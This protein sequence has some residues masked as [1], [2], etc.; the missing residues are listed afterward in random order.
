[1]PDA[2][3]RAL[4]ELG[5]EF[6]QFGP[7]V[8]LNPS[9]AEQFGL[10]SIASAT[11]NL[12]PGDRNL[13]RTLGIAR[14]AGFEAVS[15][16]AGG[17]LLNDAEVFGRAG[18]IA[19]AQAELGVRVVL[20]THRATI[21]ESISRTVEIAERF[22]D[23]RFNLDLSH[24]FVTHRLDRVSLEE[25]VEQASVVLTRVE[26]LHGRVSSF[27]E[28]QTPLSEARCRDMFQGVW[29]WV[30]AHAEVPV[31]FAPELLPTT[32]G[33]ARRTDRARWEDSLELLRSSR[34]IR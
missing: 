29:D 24:W 1:M 11:W 30:V 28:I 27:D 7:A 2:T 15:L 23:L 33:Y 20:E 18:E 10:R 25:F 34:V 17:N 16:L 3:L 22:P 19:E 4:A 5:L 21:T 6:V 12:F 26:L 14:D 13:R 31:G 9:R 32:M 8:R